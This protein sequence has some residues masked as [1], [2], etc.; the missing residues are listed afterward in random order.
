MRA[1]LMESF[2][3]VG[4]LRLG[5]LEPARA[6]E[7]EIVL[8]VLY[9]ALNPADDYLAEGQYPARPALPHVLGRDGLGIVREI[10]PAKAATTASSDDGETWR[11]GDRAILLRGEVGVSRRGTF[12]ERVVVPVESLVRPPEGWTDEQAAC[13]TLAWL[14]A[15]QA[16][17]QWIDLPRPAWI[18]V[19]GASGGV[20]IAAVQ[21]ADALGHRVVALSRSG[22]KR[23]VLRSIGADLVADPSDEGWPVRLR[24]HLGGRT[25]DLVIDNVAGEHFPRLVDT[26]AM[27]G[28]IS[29]VGRLAGPVP[30]FNTGSLFFRRLQVRGVSVGSYTPGQARSAWQ[31]L[32]RSL[33]GR[34]PLVD[35]VLAF[36]ELPAAFERLRA[37]PLGKVLLRV[38][39]RGESK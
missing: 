10:G 21:L 25:I 29:C 36:E 16:I 39:G 19:T 5:N 11:T 31:S 3:G 26:L 37:G 38:A 15:W 34:R 32:L 35:S 28:R 17:T 20:G 13:G 18:L 12:A 1:W 6:A 23:E 30:R 2:G 27:N 7:G 4:S 14:T 8:D 22:P 24:E 9:A 33:G